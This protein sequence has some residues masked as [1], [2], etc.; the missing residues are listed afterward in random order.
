MSCE[1]CKKEFECTLETMNRCVHCEY[2]LCDDCYGGN[3]EK[4]NT[5]NVD[6]CYDCVIRT[7]NNFLLSILHHYMQN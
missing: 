7:Y 3:T 6:V 1:I 4:C 2:L 5:C